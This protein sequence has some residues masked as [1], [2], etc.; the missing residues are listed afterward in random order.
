[1]SGKESGQ[2]SLLFNLLSVLG[3]TFLIAALS[4]N[5]LI[6]DVHRL[7]DLSTERALILNTRI[8]QYELG[9]KGSE[10]DLQVNQFRVVHLQEHTGDLACQ[11][12]L[13][14]LDLREESFSQKL[15][16]LLWLN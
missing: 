2:L 10:R 7:V 1:M 3:F 5:I 12:W 13:K 4:L 14:D 8:C 9:H 11:L 15:F 16:L 6:I